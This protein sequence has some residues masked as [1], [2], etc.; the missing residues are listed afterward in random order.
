MNANMTRTPAPKVHL[1]AKGGTVELIAGKARSLDLLQ[2]GQG[3][4]LAVTTEG[5]TAARYYVLAPEKTL[6]RWGHVQTGWQVVEQ[7]PAGDAH[8]A[9]VYYLP[10]DVTAC[11]C[12]DAKYRSRPGGCKH[13][14]FVA[15]ALKAIGWEG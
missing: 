7:L 6:T 10:L 15:A 11:T 9:E 2:R 8:E 5:E 1:A 4:D 3:V 13:R 14:R 12:N